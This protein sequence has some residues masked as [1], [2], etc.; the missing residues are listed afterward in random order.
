MSRSTRTRGVGEAG[1]S[2]AELIVAIAIIGL[3]VT[4]LVTGLA[5]S[6]SASSGHRQHAS[7]DTI[8]RSV[9]E[10][11]KDRSVA[12]DPNGSYASSTWTSVLSS[13]DQSDFDI[14]VSAKCLKSANESDTSLDDSKFETCNA[15]TTGDQLISVTA[16]ATTGKGESDTVTILKRRS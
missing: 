9:A 13:N 10:A 2:L 7:A 14:S 6:I 16:T 4:V 1:E 12:L 5:T 8:A 11:L 3:A 15:S